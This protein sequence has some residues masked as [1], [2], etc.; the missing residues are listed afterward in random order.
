MLHAGVIIYNSLPESIRNI[1]DDLDKFKF[2][3]DRYLKLLPD[4][5]AVPGAVP[6]ARDM[7]G[8][9]SNSIV[10]WARIVDTSNDF[11]TVVDDSE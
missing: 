3:L 6:A 2:E 7:Y 8:A 5:P 1:N 9:P 10:D 11:P 4:Q